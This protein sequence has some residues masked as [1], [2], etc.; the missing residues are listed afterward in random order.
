MSLVFT[1]EFTEATVSFNLESPTV[2][3]TEVYFPSMV[4]CNANVLRRSFTHS[5]LRDPEVKNLNLDFVQL[6]RV[7]E[8]VFI[9]GDS[10]VPSQEYEDIIRVVLNSQAYDNMAREFVAQ[11]LHNE[12]GVANVPISTWHSL[13]EADLDKWDQV[14]VSPSSTFFST[15]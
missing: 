5:L 8:E 10:E 13:W 7:I 4:V 6:Q 3:L 11:S 9:K 1:Q 15:S 14:K 12:S 2:P